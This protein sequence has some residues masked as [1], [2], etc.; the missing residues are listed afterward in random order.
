M[1]QPI[2]RSKILRAQSRVNGPTNY[3]FRTSGGGSK[4]WA[5]AFTM[6]TPTAYRSLPPKAARFD[7]M[8]LASVVAMLLGLLPFLTQDGACVIGD[9]GVFSRRPTSSASARK[10]QAGCTFRPIYF[11]AGDAQPSMPTE[12]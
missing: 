11:V 3:F 4:C 5:S 1:V 6:R 10:V 8:S 12:L 2:L 9:N 7:P